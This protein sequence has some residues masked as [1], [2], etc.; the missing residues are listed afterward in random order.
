[1]LLESTDIRQTL[2]FLILLDGLEARG[3]SN[4]KRMRE[5]GIFDYN[6]Y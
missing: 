3:T 4:P 2:R 1:M 6:T 5:I